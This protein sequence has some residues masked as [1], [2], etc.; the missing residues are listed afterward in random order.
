MLHRIYGRTLLVTMIVCLGL[1]MSAVT[2][3]A[4]EVFIPSAV[5]HPYTGILYTDDFSDPDSGWAIFENETGKTS[6]VDSEYELL[7]KTNNTNLVFNHAQTFSSYSFQVD[8]RL[9]PADAQRVYGIVFGLKNLQ[10]YFSFLVDDRGLFSV[11]RLTDNQW[12]ILHDWQESPIALNAPP[13]MNR[14]RVDHIG[15]GYVVYINEQE[16]ARGTDPRLAGALEIGL[17]FTNYTPNR[18]ASVRFDNLEVRALPDQVD[19]N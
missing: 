3:Q 12:S 18:T 2:T 1:A 11:H 19:A 17:T 5:N 15:E 9:L 6:Y 8:A 4:E 16:V 14:F 10:N 7:L 13:A